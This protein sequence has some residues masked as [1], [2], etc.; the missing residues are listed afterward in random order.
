VADEDDL[1]GV[2]QRTTL[3]RPRTGK[4]PRVQPSDP[5]PPTSRPSTTTSSKTTAAGWFPDPTGRFEFRYHNGERWTNDVSVD[6][7][8]YVDPVGITTPGSVPAASGPAAPGPASSGP[9]PSAPAPSGPPVAGAVPLPPGSIARPPGRGKAILAFLLGLGGVALAWTPFLFVIGLGLAVAALVLGV[10]VLRRRPTSGVRGFAVAAVALAPTAV[11]LAPV[12]AWLT[13]VTW[14]E[15][16]EYLD[17]GPVAAEVTSCDVVGTR[18]EVTGTVRNLGD[19]TR[20]YVVVVEIR[21]GG[22]VV[23][24]IDARVD[25]VAPDATAEWTAQ[26]FVGD[27]AQPSCRVRDVTGPYPFDL[28]TGS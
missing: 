26:G 15:F 10:Q 18:A 11:V 8:R 7:E 20:T 27:V 25:G 28:D 22:D 2:G 13:V 9:A 6:G 17:P 4:F 19:E 16:D 3:G 14:R 23:D 12:G 21:E 1:H 5:L 24:R